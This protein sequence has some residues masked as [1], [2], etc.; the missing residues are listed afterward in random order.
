M[1]NANEVYLIDVLQDVGLSKEQINNILR[2]LAGWRIHIRKNK[3]E[4]QMIKIFYEAKKELGME[5]H[6]IIKLA[7]S[8]FNKSE[9]RIREIINE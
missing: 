1:I 4:N 9:N 5:K 3:T 2:R 6:K 7:A 8:I